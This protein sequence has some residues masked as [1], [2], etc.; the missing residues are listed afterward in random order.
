MVRGKA[1]PA[2]AD[3][4]DNHAMQHQ[5]GRGVRSRRYVGQ[6]HPVAGACWRCGKYDPRADRAR[7]EPFGLVATG[8]AGTQSFT[9]VKRATETPSLKIGPI[10]AAPCQTPASNTKYREN[11][12]YIKC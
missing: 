1:R 5:H 7:T 10:R 6:W 9:A 3:L 2:R 4:Y 12:S 11:R 8:G